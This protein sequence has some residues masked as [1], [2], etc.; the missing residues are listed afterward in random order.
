MGKV[1]WGTSSKAVDD[2][3]ERESDFK[4]YE[5]DV[6][7][8]GVYRLAAR[9]LRVEDFNSGSKGLNMLWIVDEPKS[10]AKAVYNGA[11]LW[12]RLVD[13]D[14]QSWKI[15]QFM[16]AIGGTGRHWANTVTVTD[17]RD[18]EAV[19]KFG[20]ILTE[21]LRAKALLKRGSYNGA[22]RAEVSRWMPKSDESEDDSGDGDSDG[23]SDDDTEPPF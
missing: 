17:E 2:A 20:N 12:E 16:R 7:P 22:P 23:S 5:G 21:G 14:T 1:K 11:P 6:P 18:N 3:E 15:K 13:T 8:A 4:P 10:S 19:Q 9:F